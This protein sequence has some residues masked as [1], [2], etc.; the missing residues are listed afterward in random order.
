[1]KY[2][3]LPIIFLTY[4]AN[5]ERT[6]YAIRTVRSNMANLEYDGE[7][8]WIVADDGSSN[9]HWNAVCSLADPLAYF[10]FRS[11]RAGYGSN[12]N[13]AWAIARAIGPVSFWLEDDWELQERTNITPYVEMLLEQESVG[14][15]RLGYLPVDL[16]ITTVGLN[17]RVYLAVHKGVQYAFSGNPHL[18]HTRFFEAYGE[19]SE[20]YAP[21]DTEVDYD[22]KVRHSE[23]PLIVRPAALNE[24]GP[25]G[26]IGMVKSYE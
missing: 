1:M 11:D 7:L 5:A 20:E 9:H 10:S 23:G 22:H 15:V 14:M 2:P 6:E 12:A 17:G 21:G 4:G 19:Y 16:T 24:W 26:H 13:K 3:V 18:K 25:W 8:L